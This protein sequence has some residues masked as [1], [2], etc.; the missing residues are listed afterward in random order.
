[1]SVIHLPLTL[2]N[3]MKIEQLDELKEEVET[4]VKNLLGGKPK[5]VIL[6]GSYSR[7]DYDEESDIDFAV[8]ADID[9]TMIDN[10]DNDFVDIELDLLLK[11]DIDVS[12]LLFSEEKIIEYKNIVPYYSNLVKEGIE[13]YGR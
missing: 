8:I 10:F 6:Y 5:K 1:M 2:K 11:Y 12:I 13:I 7:G 4:L 9:S 3:D